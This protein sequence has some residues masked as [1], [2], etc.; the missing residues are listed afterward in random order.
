[1]LGFYQSV[2]LCTKYYIFTVWNLFRLL[3]GFAEQE[4]L[5]FFHTKIGYKN[6]LWRHEEMD[7]SIFI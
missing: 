6:Q 1:M 7:L 5:S 4:W 2:K 3:F